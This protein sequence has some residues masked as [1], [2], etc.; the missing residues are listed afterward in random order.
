MGID[1]CDFY[2][3]Y[4]GALSFRYKIR[5]TL[6]ARQEKKSPY[7]VMGATSVIQFPRFTGVTFLIIFQKHNAMEGVNI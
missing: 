2:D 3:Y 1:T 6:C 4:Q 5:K 7:R